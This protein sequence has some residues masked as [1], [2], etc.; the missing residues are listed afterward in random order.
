MSIQHRSRIKSVA[1]YSSN[2]TDKGAC[3]YARATSP[4]LEYYNTCISN[5]GHWTPVENEDISGVACP[6]LG[7]TGCCCACSYVSDFDSETGFF[8]AYSESSGNCINANNSGFNYPCYQGGLQDNI[9]FCE[10][11]DKGGVWAEGVTC[12]V[13]T[14][15]SGGGDT[16]INEYIPIGAHILCTKGINQ[17]EFDVRWPGA[18]CSGETCDNVCSTKECLEAANGWGV[19]S[20]IEF[21]PNMFCTEPT[22]DS[23]PGSGDDVI[24][25][26]SSTEGFVGDD[27]DYDKDKRTGVFVLKDN[28]NNTLDRTFNSS[29]PSK[30]KSSCLYLQR[31]GSTQELVCSNETK[32]VCDSKRGMWSGFNKDNQPISCTDSV[33]LDVRNYIEN[34]KKVSRAI[35]DGWNLGERVLNLGRYVGEFIVKDDTHGIGSECYGSETTGSSYSYYPKNT[36]NTANSNK[37]FAIV[38]ADQDFNYRVVQDAGW[39]YEI[40]NTV[41]EVQGSSTWDSIYNTTYNKHLMLVNNINNSYNNNIWGGWTV[42]SKAM[43]SFVYTQTRDV[44]FISNTTIEDTNTNTPHVPLTRHNSVFY[45]SSTFLTD[46]DY[47]GKTQLAYCQSFNDNSMVVLSPRDKYHKV[48]LV[49]VIEII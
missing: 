23:Y 26:C 37:T 15:V 43:L 14:G 16:G 29:T 33:A 1:D 20:D 34:K 6:E 2:L 19:Y 42:P 40:S 7:A 4:I 46:I 32:N 9:T 44:D 36:D 11:T 8:N 17:T 38:I 5:G 47:A 39:C 28:F 18:C 21:A 48:R 12:G 45:W 27:K 41:S 30:N 22:G 49:Q 31:N 10:C 35:V 24:M 13:Y 25:T 3:C